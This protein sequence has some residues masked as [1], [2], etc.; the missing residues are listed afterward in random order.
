VATVVYSAPELGNLE[1]V[2]E[3]LAQDDPAA[4]LDATTAI[5]SAVSMLAAHLLIG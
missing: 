5:Q 4:A 1:R 3:Y 2:F